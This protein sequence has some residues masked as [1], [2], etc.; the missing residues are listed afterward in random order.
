[1]TEPIRVVLAGV[2]AFLS[3][4]AASPPA[5]AP[6]VRPGNLVWLDPTPAQVFPQSDAEKERQK[7]TG[8]I[9]PTREVLRPDVDPALA[10]YV[11]TAGLSIERAFRVGSSD[12]MPG[13]VEGWAAAFARF[14]PGF[15]ITIERPLAGSLGAVELIK[16]N[17][18]FVFVSRELRPNDVAQFRD[19][20]GYDPTSFPVS[21]GSWRHFGFLDAVP[22]IV[23]PDNPVARL[24]FAQIDAAFS[25]TRHRGAHAVATWG[26]LGLTGAWAKRPVHLYGIRPWNGFEEFVRQRVLSVPGKRG[27]WRADIAY[28]DTFFN[29]AR[30]VAADPQAL[31]YSGLSALDSAVKIVPLGDSGA[32]VSP[33][34]EAVATAAYPLSRV[35]YL[36]A[37]VAPGKPAD[38]A[39]AEFLRF[40]LSRD[41]QAVVREQ[42]VFLPLRAGQIAASR[43]LLNG[44]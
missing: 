13:L 31:G 20:F 11:P 22:I 36:N 28:D 17:L 43:A 33:T 26:D 44:H 5:P 14:H 6:A 8:R 18:D 29:V 34:Y 9:L 39:L 25:A 10:P 40:I 27:E 16:G 1:M 41:G 23:N 4:A 15:R 24:S 21:G 12:I 30:R 2:V 19:K 38:P 3:V 32:G 37:N 35:T 7:E 42:G